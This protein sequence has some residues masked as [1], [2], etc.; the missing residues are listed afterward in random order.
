[1]ARGEEILYELMS[2][3]GGLV[4]GIPPEHILDHECDIIQNFIPI[5]TRLRARN[6]SYGTTRITSVPYGENVT[7]LFPFKL[8]TGMWLLLAGTAS[9]IAKLDGTALVA[10]PVAD[11]QVYASSAE[12]WHFRQY[13][14]EV[15]SVRRATGTMKRV[16]QDNVMDAGIPAPSVAPTIADGGAGNLDAG[17]FVPVFTFYN[18]GTAAESN[19]SPAGATL[20][21]VADRQLAWSNIGVSLSGQVNARRLYRTLPS[22]PGEY[23]FVAQINDNFT[24]TYVDNVIVANQGR[25]VSFDNGLPPPGLDLLEIWRERA[26]V[27]DGTEVFYSNVFAGISNVQGFGESNHF[28]VT[29]DDGHRIRVLHAHGAQLIIGKTNAV[30]YVIPAGGGFAREVLSDRHGCVAPFSMKTAE[31]LLFWYSGDNVYRSDGV[32]VVSISTI[33]IRKKLDR[34]PDL[35]KEKVVAAVLPELSLYILTVSQGSLTQNELMLAYNYKTDVWTTNTLPDGVCPAFIGDFFDTSY[36]Q[37]LYAAL[38]DGHVYQ[39]FNG[40]DDFGT[41]IEA[42]VRGKGLGLDRPTFRKGVRRISLL[43]SSVPETVF[44]A[45]FNDGAGGDDEQ[46][47]AFRSVSLDQGTEWKRISLSTMGNLGM[48]LQWAVSYAGRSPFELSGVALEAVGF[49]RMGKVL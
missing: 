44:V 41:P 27:S 29:P 9:G 49:K 48:T 14:N 6:G 25:Q 19:P 8:S 35:M 24:T 3:G 39:L 38:Y 40:A 17:D 33:K 30:H 15:L 5:G 26:W 34:I 31:R 2:L 47:A 21:Q 12:P 4:D 42:F 43:C 18:Q 16:T 1:V 7:S 20:T 32:N 10:L 11:G 13:K 37:V 46:A 36:A 22:Q 28:P 45:V 23:Y